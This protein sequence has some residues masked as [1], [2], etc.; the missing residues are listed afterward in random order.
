M[1]MLCTLKPVVIICGQCNY[2]VSSQDKC[3]RL[4]SQ[5]ITQSV[6]RVGAFVVL[7]LKGSLVNESS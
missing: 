3:V 1:H 7:G 2:V 6:M 5:S 4:S